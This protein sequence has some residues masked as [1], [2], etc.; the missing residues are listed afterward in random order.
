MLARTA[1]NLFWLARYMERADFIARMIE[2]TLRLEYLPRGGIAASGGEW[3]SALEAE[4][5]D[6]AAPVR[7]SLRR[8]DGVLRPRKRP[9]KSGPNSPPTADPICAASRPA[10]P[11]SLSED[12][13]PR[14]D[15]TP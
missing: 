13:C 9:A 15:P 14:S 11:F 12:C 3:E 2:A 4:L 1:D 7:M 6:L 5:D 10:R 8:L